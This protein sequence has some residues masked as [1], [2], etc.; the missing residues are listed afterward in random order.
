MDHIIFIGGLDSTGQ[1]IAETRKYDQEKWTD[2]LVK[3]P[4]YMHKNMPTPLAYASAGQVGGSVII[5]GGLVGMDPQSVTDKC[6]TL[7]ADYTHWKAL[8]PMSMARAKAA[9]H[10][11]G[12]ILI[13]AGGEDATGT[14]TGRAEKFR[15]R[16]WVPISNLPTAT[17]GYGNLL[18]DSAVSIVLLYLKL[19]LRVEGYGQPPDAG[20]EL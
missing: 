8:P 12:D 13:V 3:L 9:H 2:S 16:E 14:A 4:G 15:D 10:S 18:N 1:I 6:W 19:M 17:K 20:R 7:L 5:C 11:N